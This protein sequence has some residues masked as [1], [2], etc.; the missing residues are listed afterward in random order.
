LLITS[1]GSAGA[2]GIV[3][4]S[5]ENI[6]RARCSQH[7]QGALRTREKQQEEQ[8]RT[9]RDQERILRSNSHQVPPRKSV[10]GW[11]PVN[12]FYPHTWETGSCHSEYKNVFLFK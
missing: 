2:P 7:H 4:D 5:Q 6:R 10:K 11:F 8:E 12:E 3:Q 1:R 9:T